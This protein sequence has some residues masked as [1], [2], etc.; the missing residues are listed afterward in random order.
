M[1]SLWQKIRT[2]FSAKLHDVVDRTLEKND[3]AVYDEY[4]RQAAKEI[5]QFKKLTV[6]MYGQVKTTKRRRE[7]LAEKATKMDAA[8][9]RFLQS[10]KRTQ[11]MVTLKQFNSAMDMIKTYD[12]SLKKQVVALEQIE[13]IRIKLEGRLATARQEREE[14]VYL[15]E[16]AKSKEVATKA[17]RSLDDLMGQGNSDVA[18]AAENIRSRLD[19]ADASWEVQTSRL[20]HQLDGAMKDLEVEAE[21]AARMDRLGL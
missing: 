17:M 6:P 14:L 9:D 5:E 16:L 12:S 20:D 19:H 4:I 21:L 13:D 8:I 2:L 7:A 10:G 3:I 15:L 11:A 1:A 18:N